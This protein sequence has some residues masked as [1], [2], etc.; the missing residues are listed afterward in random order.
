MKKI[1]ELK[2]TNELLSQRLGTIKSKLNGKVSKT[3]NFSE[4]II[5]QKFSDDSYFNFYSVEQ[6]IKSS[7]ITEK[8]FVRIICTSGKIK[9][10]ILPFN[11][12]TIVKSP[13]T[14]LITPNT[15]YFIE[16]IEDSEIIIVHKTKKENARYKIMEEKTIYNKL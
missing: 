14:Q 4:H 7:I 5:Y 6:N 13:N 1:S 8:D 12:E 11:E 10:N 16:T 15:P 9:V 3:L 2:K